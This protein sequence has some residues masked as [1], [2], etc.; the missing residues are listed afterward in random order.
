MLKKKMAMFLILLIVISTSLPAFATDKKTIDVAVKDTAEY[1]LKTVK[2][3]QVVSIGGEWV[4]IGLA[5]SGYNVPDAYYENYYKTVE[6]YVA[7]CKG[8]LHDKKYTE[9]SRVILALTAAGYDPRNVAGYDLTIPLG[10]FEKTIWQGINGPIFALLALDSANYPMPENSEAKTQATRDLY[11]AEILCRQLTDGGFNLTANG[12]INQNEKADADLTA[13]ALQALAKYQHMPE[14]RAAID[15]AID[16]LIAMQNTSGGYAS[17]GTSNSESTVQVLVALCELGISLD[18]P[19]FVKNGKTLADNILSFSNG[20]GSF[21]HTH[22]GSGNNQMS[23]EQAFYGLVAAQRAM[24][25]KNSLYRM[26]DVVKR[27]KDTFNEEDKQEMGLPDKNV[28]VKALPII[29]PGKTFDDIQGYKNQRA[30]EALAARGIIGGKSSTEFDPDATMTRAE[31]A[32]IITRALAL[33]Q[34]P[35]AVFTDV[36]E[37]AWYAGYVGTALNYGIV[38][39]TSDTTFNPNGTI[40][41]EEAAVMVARAAK[42]CGMKTTL[43]EITIRDMLAQFDDYITVSD[44]AKSSLAFCYEADILPQENIDIRPK[45]A[46]LRCEVAEMLFRLLGAANLL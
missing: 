4:I 46:I 37:E 36:P 35:V 17:W 20:D 24:E 39:G 15:K 44:W 34:K 33:S 32:T 18:D 21:K 10:D 41:R 28:D 12:Q 1:I 13:M 5:R 3:P 30:I 9:Y 25:G 14:V 16:C 6:K 22:D 45:E 29:N 26:N 7:E 38:N 23:T 11:I 19:R 2:N 43:D 8:V 40:T 27:T 42:L 31:F